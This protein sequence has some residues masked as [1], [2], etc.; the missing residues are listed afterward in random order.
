VDLDSILIY[1]HLNYDCRINKEKIIMKKVKVIM[2]LSLYFY[3][4]LKKKF[5]PQISVTEDV[6]L[7]VDYIPN[8]TISQL[9]NRLNIK[10]DETG[11]CFVNHKVVGSFDE[12]LEDGSRIAIFSRGMYLIDGGMFIRGHAYIQK[13][14]PVRIDF[15]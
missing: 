7:E 12:L 6:A 5:F 14:P 13:K 15:Y 1:F 9:L 4:M 11:E 3:G 10:Q 8:E 2:L